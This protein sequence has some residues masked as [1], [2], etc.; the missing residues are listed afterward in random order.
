MR[1]LASVNSLM[2]QGTAYSNYLLIKILGIK[3]KNTIV[4]KCLTNRKT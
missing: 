4:Y 3:I 1:Q 2:A